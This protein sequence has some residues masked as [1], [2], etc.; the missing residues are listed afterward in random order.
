MSDDT[1][2]ASGIAPQK[3]YKLTDLAAHSD[4]SIVSRTLMNSSSGSLT[5]FSFAEGQ[6]LSE[7]TA[8]FDALVHVIEGVAE[9][10]IDGVAMN[11]DQGQVVLMPANIPHAVHAKQPF[12][13][14]LTMFKSPKS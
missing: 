13:M 14:A 12:K 4:D 11:V 8:P 10:T 1:T 2:K 7:H 6:R 3:V 9:I 5:L